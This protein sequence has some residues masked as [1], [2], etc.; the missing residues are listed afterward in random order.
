M[1]LPLL[2]PVV[3]GG[4]ALLLL[5]KSST[6]PKITAPLAPQTPPG[7]P[8]LQGASC[9]TGDLQEPLLTAA[10]LAILN[11]TKADDLEAFAKYLDSFAPPCTLTSTRARSKA[12]ALRAVPSP[13]VIPLPVPPVIP[14]GVPSIPNGSCDASGATVEPLNTAVNNA[15]VQATDPVTLDQLAITL[16]SMVPPCSVMSARVRARAA[17]LRGIIAPP[18]GI[19]KSQYSYPLDTYV[20]YQVKT[21]D[22]PKT[23]A[24]KI[25]GL[26]P[27]W[28]E[29]AAENPTGVSII[30][31]GDTF[32]AGVSKD[33]GNITS[34]IKLPKTWNQYIRADL[35]GY[36][37]GSPLP[38]LPAGET[39]AKFSNTTDLSLIKVFTESKKNLLLGR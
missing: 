15:I 34:W 1:A 5:A 4:A 29:L 24:T 31:N 20:W 22:T 19:D 23:V 21:D 6:A 9:S 3:L 2:I 33:S 10:N 25:T 30:S 37:A 38:T 28:I 13:L 32:L 18:S 26:S 17:V 39:P 36:T 7:Y 16:D 8:T 14:A 12:A 11:A 27:R 35:S